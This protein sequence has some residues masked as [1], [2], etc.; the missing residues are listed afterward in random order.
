MILDWLDRILARIL[1]VRTRNGGDHARVKGDVFDHDRAE[2]L[3]D[4]F[5]PNCRDG[6]YSSAPDSPLAFRSFGD[7]NLGAAAVSVPLEV[8]HPKN[9][10][11]GTRRDDLCGPD[12]IAG[13]GADRAEPCG[14]RAMQPHA[15]EGAGLLQTR[16]RPLPVP[17]LASERPDTPTNEQMG[18]WHR[19]AQGV[20]PDWVIEALGGHDSVD[21][22]VDSIC[23]RAGAA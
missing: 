19:R 4:D 12:P 18:L 21:A 20:L 8:H 3:G 1:P 6:S 13:T 16:V 7:P 22:C 10:Q 5:L 11:A 9:E 23:R 17:P 2:Q 14:S 15:S